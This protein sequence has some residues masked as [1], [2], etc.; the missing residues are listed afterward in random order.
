MKAEVWKIGKRGGEMLLKQ[1]IGCS[2][3]WEGLFKHD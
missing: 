1:V 2:A 3:P